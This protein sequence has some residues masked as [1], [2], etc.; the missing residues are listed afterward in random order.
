M[1]NYIKEAKNGF[2]L[3]R[4]NSHSFQV[5]EARM[6]LPLLAYNLTNW[7]ANPLFSRREKEHAN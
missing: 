4:M 3:D 5:N 7:A 6:M 2:G 1:E